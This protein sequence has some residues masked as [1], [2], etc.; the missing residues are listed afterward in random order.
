MTFSHSVLLT[1]GMSKFE[2]KGLIFVNPRIKIKMLLWLDL[3]VAAV[4]RHDPTWGW[5]RPHST[6]LD[7]TWQWHV[8]WVDFKRLHLKNIYAFTAGQSS[9]LVYKRS[10]N[11]KI[12]QYEYATPWVTHERL[13]VRWRR[14]LAVVLVRKTKSITLRRKIDELKS[15]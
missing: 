7:F 10:Q 4:Q 2:Y 3:R 6:W 13:C 15:M 9:S 11:S 5:N 14:H 12:W 8:T 1:L